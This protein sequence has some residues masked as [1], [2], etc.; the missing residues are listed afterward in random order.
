MDITY[1]AKKIIS[2]EQFIDL[3]KRS[4]LGER[5]P[6]D[7]Y[8]CIQGML[9]NAGLLVTAWDGDLLIGV[10]RS[11]TDFHFA[12]YLSDL[13]VDTSYQKSG[14]GRRLIAMTQESLGPKCKIILLSAPAATEYY[15]HLGMIKHESAWTLPRSTPVRTK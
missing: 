2:A 4:T 13:A 3:L 14:I 7:D 15:P 11:V 9:D 5:R 1:S 8:G 12:C 10:S 6:I